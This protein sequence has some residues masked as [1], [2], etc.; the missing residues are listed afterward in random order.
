MPLKITR[1]SDPITVDRLTCVI[2][3][4]PGIGKTSLSFTANNPLLL[5]FDRGSHRAVNR[6][7]TVQIETWAD[8]AAIS[9]EDVEPYDTV[10]LDT[11]G[12][13][14]DVLTEYIMGDPK[15]TTKDRAK[16]SIQGYGVLKNTFTGFCKRLNTFGK[17]VILIAHMDE[18]KSGD[19]VVERL[20]VTGG[21]KGEI[22][23]AADMM[24][25][26]IMV[27]GRRELRF[28]PSDTSFGKNPGQLQP[29]LVPDHSD[30]AFATIMANAIEATKTRLNELTEAQKEAITEQEWFRK[31]LP[32]IDSADKINGLLDRAT[33]SGRVAKALVNDRA[34]EL[35]LTYSKNDGLYVAP[36]I[37]PGA[38]E[39]SEAA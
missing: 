12:R 2:Y 15:N 28:S 31:A 4:Q 14:L 39:I 26:L 34:K 6:K 1:S 3:A 13:A 37:T 10:I 19:E 32:K 11:A 7:D 21:S 9:A 24:G 25:R 27:G 36:S 16:L 18:Q 5:D 20:D 17:D 23:K 33:A 30:P 22:Y 8:V 29:I 35:G 38:P